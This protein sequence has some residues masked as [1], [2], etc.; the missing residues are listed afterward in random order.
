M[1]CCRQ[2]VPEHLR[3]NPYI[4][5]GYRPP[6]RPVQ[7]LA[8]VFA[9]H[10]ETVN[11]YTHVVAL[12][13]S[14]Y[15]VICESPLWW[16]TDG[17][18]FIKWCH[19]IATIIPWI[20]SIVYHTFMNVN[21]DRD[22]YNRLLKADLLGIWLAQYL[23]GMPMMSASLY[24]LSDTNQLAVKTIYWTACFCGL[25]KVIHEQ[26]FI[27]VSRVYFF[28][29]ITIRILLVALRTTRYGGGDP[30]A[31]V[32]VVLADSSSIIGGIINAARWPERRFPGTC[33]FFCN[34]HN[35][36]HLL[37]LLAMYWMHQVNVKDIVWLT[38]QMNFKNIQ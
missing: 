32:Y 31:I 18:E 34:S 35:I 10:N 20:G 11:I 28:L 15:L 3:F 6:M 5:Y 26:N 27:K 16:Y 13:L 30:A 29:P 24:N 22:T 19:I 38:A 25:L 9:V 21:G 2:D 12:C 17:I 4:E 8:S 37:V 1:S 14:L 7:C 33:D 36:M 23:G